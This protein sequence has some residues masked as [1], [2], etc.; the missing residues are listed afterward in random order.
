MPLMLPGGVVISDP[1]RFPQMQHL[2]AFL[3]REGVWVEVALM[4]DIVLASEDAYQARGGRTP[5]P[6][7][8]SST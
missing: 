2:S 6:G 7:E 3:G 1:T 4:G 5:L 8:T